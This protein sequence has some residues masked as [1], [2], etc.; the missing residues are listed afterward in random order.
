MR[1]RPPDRRTSR[2]TLAP[3]LAALT[4]VGPL[5]VDTYLPSMAEI[6]RVL[7]APPVTVQQTLT[8]Y[9]LP[10]A[11]MTL[12]HGAI[13]DSMGRRRVILWGTGLYVIAS[14]GCV[15][16]RSIE[17]LLL[18]RA[19]QGMT[20]G[21]GM[22]VGRAVVR[23]L[24]HGPEAQRL[25]S[26][27]TLVFALAPA[28]APILGGWLQV[29][30]GWRSVFVFL[31][32]FGSL[33]WI[34]SRL[35]LP[36]TLPPERRQPLHAGRLLRSYSAVLTRPTFLAACFAMTLNFAGV[37]FYIVSAPVFV[38]QH[39][40]LPA[41]QFIWLFGPITLGMACGAWASSRSAGR[42][43]TRQLIRVGYAVMLA[44]SALNL[45]LSRWVAP[46]VPWSV[47]PLL[48]YS[49]GMSLVFPAITISALD[50]FPSQRGLAASCQSF[51]QTLGAAL[52]AVL[53]PVLWSNVQAMAVA[54]FI[55]VALGGLLCAAHFARRR[56]RDPEAP[57]PALAHPAPAP[58]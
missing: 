25:M 37:F 34:L 23:D 44:M 54:Q 50:L 8:A 43:P 40:H 4:A 58:E 36:E 19:L 49:F 56:T 16:V 13:S 30:F 17:S 6:G 28:I 57:G 45:G 2:P 26:Q 21:A 14:L 31:L 9:M 7:H 15:F 33:A 1:T 41:T 32:L 18:F 55:C 51:V 12:W 10:F 5:S 35:Y 27:V 20:A 11:L 22:V 46:G 53:A 24:H 47:A 3:L 48:V 39:L 38:M 42:V 52:I 29:S